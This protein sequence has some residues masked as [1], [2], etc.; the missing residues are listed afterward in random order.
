MDVTMM[1]TM[2]RLRDQKKVDVK[3]AHAAAYTRVPMR[4]CLFPKSFFLFWVHCICPILELRSRSRW[5]RRKGKFERN[6]RG[7]GDKKGK[8]MVDGQVGG[9]CCSLVDVT[10]YLYMCMYALFFSPRKF[11]Q[12]IVDAM[13]VALQG[14]MGCV[15]CTTVMTRK[16]TSTSTTSR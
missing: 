12:S 15:V 2:S 8:I 14:R 6:N 7:N 9:C 5:S 4:P 3:V 13:A 10:N 11:R 1:T 16:T